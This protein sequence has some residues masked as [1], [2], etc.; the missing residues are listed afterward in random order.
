[1]YFLVY[2]QRASC[3]WIIFGRLNR[4]LYAKKVANLLILY[5]VDFGDI[6]YRG[7]LSVSLVC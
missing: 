5:L 1:V 4:C 3:S 6:D 2:S 7:A